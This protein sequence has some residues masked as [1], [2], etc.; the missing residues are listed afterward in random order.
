MR[1]LVCV[2][3]ALI[4]GLMMFLVPGTPYIVSNIFGAL[5]PSVLL[6]L[7]LLG[8]CPWLLFRWGYNVDL[9][10]RTYKT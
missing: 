1:I 2:V 10:A 9:L 8:V 3:A 5:V 7:I 6:G 4:P